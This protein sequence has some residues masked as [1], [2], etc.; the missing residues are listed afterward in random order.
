MEITT[1]PWAR[2]KK[3]VYLGTVKF[4]PADTFVNATSFSQDE[5]DQLKAYFES[6]QERGQIVSPVTVYTVNDK[7]GEFTE[8][9]WEL[10]IG[11]ISALVF[12]IVNSQQPNIISWVSRSPY[13][14]RTT[15]RA[16]SL[17]TASCFRIKPIRS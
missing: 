15:K 2:L 4:V 14:G 7:T 3:P 6:F 17:T 10:L 11:A 5:A 16:C 8:E 1:I 13:G 12:Q 9:E